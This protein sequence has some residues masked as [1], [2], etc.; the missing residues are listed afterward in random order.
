MAKADLYEQVGEDDKPVQEVKLFLV[1]DNM[2]GG[3]EDDPTKEPQPAAVLHKVIH[4]HPPDQPATGGRRRTRTPARRR[5]WPSSSFG[6]SWRW[7]QRSW[8]SPSA[9][10][11]PT[12]ESW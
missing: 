10:S 1:G 8:A 12:T 7:R 2:V 3:P 5:R 4:R 9:S 11:S 6:T